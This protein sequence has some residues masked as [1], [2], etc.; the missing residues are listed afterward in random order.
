MKYL[1]FAVM[2]IKKGRFNATAPDID[3]G[4]GFIV[5]EYPIN[6]G[7]ER[8]GKFKFGSDP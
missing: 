5:V 6:T 3:V 4:K 1:L 8:N 2:I 7:T